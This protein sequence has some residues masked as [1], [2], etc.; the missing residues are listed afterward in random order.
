M[1]TFRTGLIRIADDISL[2][3]QH[4]GQ[5]FA[6]L[7]D[8][9]DRVA[10]SDGEGG[11]VATFRDHSDEGWPEV[12]VGL[13][14]DARFVYAASGMLTRVAGWTV[15]GAESEVLE[16]LSS[17]PNVPAFESRAGGGLVA[18]LGCDATLAVKGIT[19]ELTGLR[20]KQ[21]REPEAIRTVLKN[22]ATR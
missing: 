21:V 1:D 15:K 2:A 9:R 5:T 18:K 12:R 6:F 22:H 11:P 4:A 14:V 8:G 16:E 13:P 3:F 19:A 17:S 7:E 10:I 20:F